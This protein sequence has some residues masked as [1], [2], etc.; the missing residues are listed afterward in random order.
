MKIAIIGAGWVGCHLAKKFKDFHDV[1]IFDQSGFFA[2]TSFRNQNRLHMGFHYPRN[3]NTRNLCHTTFNRFYN[4][5]SV[6]ISDICKNIYSI[7]KDKS[8]LDFRTYKNIF[9]YENFNFNDYKLSEIYNIEGSIICNEKHINQNAAKKFFTNQLKSNIEINKINNSSLLELS[10]EFDL[11]INCTNN[12]IKDNTEKSYYEL[13]VV[14]LYKKNKEI[15][16]DA[17]T[18]MDGHLFSIYPFQEN[19]FTITDVEHT[20]VYKSE[21]PIIDKSIQIEDKIKKIEEK[22]KY[23]YPSF[24][25]DF[26]Y[27]DYFTSIKVK[28]YNE[29]ADR[30]PVMNAQDNIINC[31]TGKIQGIY[32]IE[33]FI[34]EYIDRKYGI[35][36]SNDKR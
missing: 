18:L 26:E 1:K 15:E 3:Y 17:L 12:S 2:E 11:V 32:L 6:V 5:Y 22:I 31:Y 10:K 29:S 13:C 30:Y 21:Q 16:F 23:F 33:D 14:L 24:N 27:V 34:N 9:T 19:I 4:D 8:V 36:R 28:K 20:P 35:N 25:K 7:P